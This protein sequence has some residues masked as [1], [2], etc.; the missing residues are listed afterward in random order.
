VTPP[1]FPARLGCPSHQRRRDRRTCRSSP[2]LRR[3]GVRSP[4]DSHRFE[5]RRL[6]AHGRIHGRL[7]A[8]HR[9]LPRRHRC[10]FIQRAE[11][12]LLLPRETVRVDLRG[13]KSVEVRLNCAVGSSFISRARCFRLRS[14]F[15]CRT[16]SRFGVG[17]SACS[18]VYSFVRD[19]HRSDMRGLHHRARSRK[20]W[21]AGG[22][23]TGPLSRLQ[24]GPA[25]HPYFNRSVLSYQPT[26]L[27][28]HA[29][30][31]SNYAGRPGNAGT[32]ISEI[33]IV[34]WGVFVG[35]CPTS[36]MARRKNQTPVANAIL[37]GTSLKFDLEF[38]RSSS[39]RWA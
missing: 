9:L 29:L 16:A 22:V 11:I 26:Q 12:A 28:G 34:A 30:R 10:D 1:V 14:R 20:F 4:E 25:K 38:P 15:A 8:L 18:I 33:Q 27:D 39:R 31:C 3:R 23:A 32:S 24:V 37:R 6:R 5:R 13:L 2:T 36:Q 19:S 21:G 7:Q 17:S 35:H